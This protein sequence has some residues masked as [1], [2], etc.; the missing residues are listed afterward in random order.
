MYI[1]SKYIYTCVYIY[2][3]IRKDKACVY[4]YLMG[5]AMNIW[6][7]QKKK[8]SPTKRIHAELTEKATETRWIELKSAH[9]PLLAEQS[10]EHQNTWK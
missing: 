8:T 2:I 9:A 1:I 6:K 10:R 4:D 5:V 7:R 3:S